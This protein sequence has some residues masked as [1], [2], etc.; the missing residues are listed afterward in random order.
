VKKKIL[1]I[2]IMLL[3]V[4]AFSAETPSQQMVGNTFNNQPF[5]YNVTKI[6]DTSD[7]TLYQITYPSPLKSIHE[8]NNTVYAEYYLPKDIK[9]DAPKRPGVIVLHILGGNFELAR[10]SSRLLAGEGIPA[11]MMKMPYYGERSIKGGRSAVMSNPELFC[12]FLPQAIADIR[13]TVDFLQSR[14]EISKD[15]VGLMG[16]SLGG[17][18]GSTAAAEDQRIYKSLF[19]LGGGNLKKIITNAREARQLREMLDK[20]PQERRQKIEA[21]LDASD[22]LTNAGKLRSRAQAGNVMMINAGSD[23]VVPKECTLQLAQQLGLENKVIWKNGLGH[24]TAMAVLPQIMDSIKDFF[25]AD[26]PPQAQN[27]QPEHNLNPAE[28]IAAVMKALGQIITFEPEEGHGHILDLSAIFTPQKSK[29]I[30]GSLQ[31]IRGSS[32]TGPDNERFRLEGQVPLLKNVMMGNGEYPWLGSVKDIVFAGT[33]EPDNNKSPLKFADP[34]LL[35]KLKVIAGAVSGM[36][37]VPDMLKQ[38]ADFTDISNPENGIAIEFTLTKLKNLNTINIKVFFKE[39]G[40]TPN[41]IIISQPE[42]FNAEITV[43]QLSVNA[44]VPDE[45]FSAP[46]GVK[47]KSVNQNDIYRMFAAIVNFL[48]ETLK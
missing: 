10:L 13:R 47:V 7:Y 8:N 30:T 36:A 19:I 41:L 24:Y 6:K 5:S 29:K 46:T 32:H 17:I 16:I 9:P 14:P 1:P 37:M 35:L 11:I 21:C 48:Q 4:T 31:F 22:P 26:L 43:N 27:E 23:E 45:V 28:R 39:D 25:A 42:K 20:L 15:R 3:T 33:D 34:G 18:I 38:Y 2:F 44:T 40:I 12:Q